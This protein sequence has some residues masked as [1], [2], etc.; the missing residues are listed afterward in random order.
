MRRRRIEIEL[1]ISE[2][3]TSEIRSLQSL[4]SPSLNSM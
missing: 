4:F 3:G 2:S 1:P